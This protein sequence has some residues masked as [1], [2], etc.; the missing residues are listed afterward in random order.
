MSQ[1][2]AASPHR[3]ALWTLKASLLLFVLGLAGGFTSIALIQPTL[4]RGQ[5]LSSISFLLGVF[6]ALLLIACWR[7]R[8]PALAYLA[9]AY[10]IVTFGL[11]LLLLKRPLEWTADLGQ[12]T[13]THILFA[14]AGL[15]LHLWL[16][17]SRLTREFLPREPASAGPA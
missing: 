8:A 6:W 16:S 5:G 7:H 12:L 15:G 9:A 10:P 11:L 3:V 4:A 14:L 1:T 17:K 13:L 2:P